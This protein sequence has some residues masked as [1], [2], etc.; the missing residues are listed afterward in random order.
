MPWI[1]KCLFRW[2]LGSLYTLYASTCI[3]LL[4]LFFSPFY[5]SIANHMNQRRKFNI[6]KTTDGGSII[7]L[8][9]ARS[10]ALWTATTKWCFKY[11]KLIKTLQKFI[12]GEFL[13]GHGNLE[14]LYTVIEFILSLRFQS[15]DL[16]WCICCMSSRYGLVS[17]SATVGISCYLLSINKSI[18]NP[19]IDHLSYCNWNNCWFS[20]EHMR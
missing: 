4:L 20:F 13:T 15:V 1:N 5:I 7:L 3:L 9:I 8:S 16:F 10:L 2:P 17:F 11:H 18:F 6:A 19:L 12:D 14:D